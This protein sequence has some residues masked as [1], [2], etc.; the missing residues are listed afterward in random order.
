M[1][2]LSPRLAMVASMAKD[3]Q[4]LADIGTDHA[5]VP[6]YLVLSGR[7]PSAIAA[8]LR[9]GPLQRAEETVAKYHLEDKVTLQ[10]S[11]GFQSLAPGCLHNFILAGMGGNLITDIFLRS[12]WVKEVGNHFVLQPQSHQ[13]DLREY[14]F[15]NGF[16]IL[17]EELCEDTGRI[18][19]AMEV[20]YTGE[21]GPSDPVSYYVGALG[22]TES[23]LKEAYFRQV[24]KRLEN[25][26]NGLRT[27]GA[28]PEEQAAIL[29]LLD[30][31]RKDVSL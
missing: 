7:I 28:N 21:P 4:P 23:P 17:R 31:I 11:D 1:I 19:V 14:L 9:P 22:K 16:S 18:Y 30:G 26:L 25:R 20:I 12:P 10:L 2:H 29:S 13:E 3:G 15:Q 6:A 8:D 24:F 5:Y 27:S